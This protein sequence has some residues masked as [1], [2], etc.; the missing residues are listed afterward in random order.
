MQVYSLTGES[1]TG[2]ST[3]AIAFAYEHDIPAIIDDGLLIYKG[4]KIAGSSAKFEKTMIAAVKRAIFNDDEDAELVKEKIAEYEIDRLLILG[5]SLRMVK[6]IAARLDLGPIDKHYY[7]QDILTAEEIEEAKHDRMTKGRHVIPLSYKQLDQNLFQKIMKKGL[8]VFSP[9]KKKIGETTIVHPYFHRRLLAKIRIETAK[10]KEKLR[11]KQAGES[12]TEIYISHQRYIYNEPVRE[13]FVKLLPELMTYLRMELTYLN[14]QIKVYYD[15]TKQF[16][17]EAMIT[18]LAY[19][20]RLI[21]H[22]VDK[23][24]ITFIPVNDHKV[25]VNE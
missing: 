6:R 19:L 15:K 20:Y 3:N 25:L 16:I 5:T 14:N 22:I 17:Y 21:V 7:I 24:N 9:Q 10:Q 13:Q 11:K 18:A 4:E 12:V 1:G 23:Y 2:K 8:D